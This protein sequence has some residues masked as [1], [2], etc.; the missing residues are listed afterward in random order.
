MKQKQKKH[1]DEFDPIP[2][3]FFD[4]GPYEVWSW[5][6]TTTYAMGPYGMK[7]IADGLCFQTAVAYDWPRKEIRVNGVTLTEAEISA[8]KARLKEAGLWLK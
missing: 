8:E 2:S 1:L 4:S 5:Q 6:A 3:H 7:K